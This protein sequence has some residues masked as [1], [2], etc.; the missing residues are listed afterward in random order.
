[1]IDMESDK[2]D[3]ALE[4]GKAEAPSPAP[5]SGKK[6]PMRSVSFKARRSVQWQGINFKVGDKDI[7]KDCWGAVSISLYI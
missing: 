5:E 3:V 2:I 1:M 4:E 7:L 6:S